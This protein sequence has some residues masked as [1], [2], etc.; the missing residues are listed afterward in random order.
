MKPYISIYIYTHYIILCSTWMY[1]NDQ[2]CIY[3]INLKHGYIARV[4]PR[5]PIYIIPVPSRREVVVQFD[6]ICPSNLRYQWSTSI[7]VITI[8]PNNIKI[9]NNNYNQIVSIL[10]FRIVFSVQRHM[11]F[12]DHQPI[13]T[14]HLLMPSLELAKRGS[15]DLEPF[16]TRQEDHG[17]TPSNC[18]NNWNGMK[19]W[20]V[21]GL[22]D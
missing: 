11:I 2:S 19:G 7:I 18:E 17:R 10:N 12:L 13:T 16:A 5:N 8:R 21:S 15:S 4:T 20:W 9:N 22:Y 1:K 3:F 14:H 6:I